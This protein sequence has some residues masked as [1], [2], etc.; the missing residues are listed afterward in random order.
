MSLTSTTLTV[1]KID[2]TG[3]LLNF[4]ISGSLSIDSNGN[5]TDSTSAATTSSSGLIKLGDGISVD[6]NG[7]LDSDHTT[8]NVSG[9]D[10]PQFDLLTNAYAEN[11]EDVIV[12]GN[13]VGLKFKTRIDVAAASA[14]A[15]AGTYYLDYLLHAV[16]KPDGDNRTH[17]MVSFEL[18]VYTSFSGA[19]IP[20]FSRNS[21]RIGT[22]PNN[23]VRSDDRLKHNEVPVE[24][25][26]ETIHKINVY[27]Y[28][29]TTTFK[30]SDYMGDVINSFKEIGVIAQELEELD[31]PL[32]SQC[33]IVPENIDKDPYRVNYHNLYCISLK[34][35]QEVS[36]DMDIEKSKLETLKSNITS[37]ETKLNNLLE[38][39]T[40][41]E[42]N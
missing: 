38:R 4:P 20:G 5:L 11:G 12:N 1:G 8:W 26:L 22:N 19:Y 3:N 15:G 25:A 18:N 37:N 29:K 40:A 7:N 30:D 39:V 13:S 23:F 17:T 28:D 14:T 34:A 41:L 31:D 21:Y 27:Q 16:M 36:A 42:N 9:M 32:L 10:N 2:C 24:N 6:T 35:L 33:V